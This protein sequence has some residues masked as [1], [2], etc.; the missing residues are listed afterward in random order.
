MKKYQI[1]EIEWFDSLHFSGWINEEKVSL[2][3]L[4]EITHKSIGYFLKENKI[5]ILIIQSHQTTE[6]PEVDAIMEIPKI[7]ILK[8]KKYG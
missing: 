8:I 4:E 2:S 5:S 6:S 3:T 1:I 7:A